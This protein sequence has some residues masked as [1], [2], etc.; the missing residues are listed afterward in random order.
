MKIT[1]ITGASSGL[2]RS[3]SELY[4][5]DGN[6]LLLVGQNLERLNETSKLAKELNDKV[7]I[8]IFQA[9]LSKKEELDRLY[10]YTVS[11]G[12]FVNILINN[13][14]FGDQNALLDM[15][16]DLQI[17]LTEVN[18]IAP[19]YLMKRYL[20]DMKKNNEGHIINVA[21]I[22]GLYPGPYMSTYHASKAYLLYLSEAVSYEVRN[23][24][25]KILALCPGP[26]KSNFVSK[27]HNDYTFTK[28][29]PVASEKVAL[30]GYKYSKKGKSFVIYGN[31]NRFTYFISHFFSRKFI[32][33]SSAKTITKGGK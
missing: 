27:A 32:T 10:E 31:G 4:A 14:G 2:G 13:A 22:A 6:N 21:S 3:F 1:L 15:D 19:L 17:K 11:K 7:F 28:I 26:F 25:I 20:D 30:L 23:T 8:D 5:H 9:D 24:N 29:K 18:C 33:S 12:Y 16:L